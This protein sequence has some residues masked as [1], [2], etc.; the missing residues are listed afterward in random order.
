MFFHYQRLD[1]N[2]CGN[3]EQE[4]VPKNAIAPSG[5]GR[6]TLVIL[7]FPADRKQSKA[8]CQAKHQVK[9]ICSQRLRRPTHATD[10]G[11]HVV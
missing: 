8:L 6:F 7:F 1:Q 11:F 2:E 5:A 9:K 10:H 4:S 3:Q